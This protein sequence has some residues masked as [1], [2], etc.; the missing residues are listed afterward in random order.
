M[1]RLES[2]APEGYT[3]TPADVFADIAKH[4]SGASGAL[5]RKHNVGPDEI[6]AILRTQNLA[7][8]GAEK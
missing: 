2:L 4:G 1:G 7:V 6:D 3:I 8:M 5:L